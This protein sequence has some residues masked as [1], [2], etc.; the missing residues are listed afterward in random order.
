M[1]LANT[2]ELHTKIER[3]CSRV[4]ELEDA[5]RLL[6]KHVSKE[7]HPLLREELLA[8]KVPELVAGGAGG[9]GGGSG[10]V[11]DSGTSPSGS[12]SHRTRS[13]RPQRGSDRD[14]GVENGGD[15][16]RYKG[17]G[18]DDGFIDA[19]GMSYFAKNS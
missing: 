8:L 5:L 7:Q 2:E 12:G 15:N 3:L 19:F 13:P 11:S 4:R 14:R 1:V 18:D 17:A 6:Q 9:G 10:A 16:G